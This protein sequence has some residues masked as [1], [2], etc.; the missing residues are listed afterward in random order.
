[1]YKND[2]FLIKTKFGLVVAQG[3]K[4]EAPSDNRIHLWETLV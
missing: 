2:C 1:M 3:Q 4:Y